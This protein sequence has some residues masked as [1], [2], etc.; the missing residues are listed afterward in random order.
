MSGAILGGASVEQAARLQMVIMFLLMSSMAFA[1]IVSA[2]LVL[3]VVIDAEHR[4]RPERIDD[5]LHAVW[6]ARRWVLDRTVG[7]LAVLVSRVSRR[8]SS[9]GGGDQHGSDDERERLLG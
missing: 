7:R 6:R 2:V 3:S 4:T 9:G 8:H 5:R 1:A